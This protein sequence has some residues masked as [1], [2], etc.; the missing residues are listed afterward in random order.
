MAEFNIKQIKNIE[1]IKSLYII[2]NLFSFLYEKQKLKLIAY[3]KHIQ[4]M[5][6]IDINHYKKISRRYKIGKKNGF[7]KEYN[8][9]KN[10]LIFKG[11]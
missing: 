9:N 10:I 6:G 11:E 3:N 8:L 2:K 5:L 7:G 1:S 4:N